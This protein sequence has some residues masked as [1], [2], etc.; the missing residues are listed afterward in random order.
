VTTGDGSDAFK[1]LATPEELVVDDVDDLVARGSIA[2]GA[3]TY[4]VMLRR[5]QV[6]ALRD[7][8]PVVLRARAEAAGKTTR[9][10]VKLAPSVTDA[11]V[12]DLDRLLATRTV[13]VTR[14]KT[15]EQIALRFEP[16]EIAALLAGRTVVVRGKVG[17]KTRLVR[18]QQP[19]VK[20][21]YAARPAAPDFAIEDLTVFLAKPVVPGADGFPFEV[22]LTSD[23]IKT[24][25]TQGRAQVK[26][27]GG[28]ELSLRLEE[29]QT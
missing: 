12:D 27:A 7:G 25:R 21:G 13:Q 16:I 1:P 3:T 24:L 9:A 8:E 28:D 5:P 11:P 17:S 23:D 14:D 20:P 22:P 15:E 2:S 6:E 29:G 10:W 4:K 19:G 26:L 18:L